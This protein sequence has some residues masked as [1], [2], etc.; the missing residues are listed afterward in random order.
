MTDVEYFYTL[1]SPW[2]Y[3]AG[4]QISEMAK[5]LGVRFIHKP[6]DFI[7]V[8]PKTGGIPLRTRPQPR[9][10]YHAVELDR[11]RKY[12]NMPL[13]LKPRYYPTNNKP[14]GHMVIATQL[15]GLDPQPL[16]FALLRALW[17]EER[18]ISAPNVRREIANDV[19]LD[20]A[21][22]LDAETAPETLAAYQANS[23]RCIDVGVFGSPTFVLKGEL[24]W[25][26]DRLTFLE[27]AIAR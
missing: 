17:G 6:F 7:E 13:N 14:A 10:A 26:Q 1:S 23:D 4:P 5:R 9:Q 27:R 24:F 21:A 8:V 2:A 12:L 3:F 19:G 11:W 25:G 15:R 22:L 16:A 18:D 20:G